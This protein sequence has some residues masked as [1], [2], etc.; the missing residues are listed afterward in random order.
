MARILT[1][2]KPSNKSGVIV[3][4]ALLGLLVAA[5][6]TM[7]ALVSAGG[8]GQTLLDATLTELEEAVRKD[9]QSVDA[10]L[11]VA[12]AYSA[13]GFNDSAIEQFQ[14][15]LKLE[16][17]NQTALMGIGRIYLAQGKDDRALEPLLKV[18]DLNKD[19]PFRFSIEQLE[20]VYYELGT[21]YQRK[22]DYAQAATYLQAALQVNPVDADAWYVLGQ[23]QQQ[24]GEFEK[25]LEAYHRS[26]RLVPDYVEAY[27]A[28]A[29]I[30]R[31]TQEKGKEK[32]ATGMIHLSG[33]ST[34][35]A[36]KDLQQAV[37]LEPE[38]AEAHEGLGL[39]MEL[40]GRKE[41]ALSNYRRALE[42]DSTLMLS[43]F[44]IQRLEGA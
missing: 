12:I 28:M 20:A 32:Y 42:L 8:S 34:E 4:L 21:I 39:T 41:E 35:D 27:R 14:E 9:P 17:N 29:E 6:V 10:R 2:V 22:G 23:T 18:V 19:N 3:R 1:L 13:R 33:R 24:A 37:A 16:E 7:W 15:V 26:V 25:A 5:G 31:L 11:S 40:L 43:Q 36:L 38:L 44:G 30:Y